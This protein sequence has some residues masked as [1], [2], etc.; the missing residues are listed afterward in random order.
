[1]SLKWKNGKS[2]DVNTEHSTV[3]VVALKPRPNNQR[4]FS[5]HSKFC[6]SSRMFVSLATIKAYFLPN[7]FA[8]DEQEMFLK[9]FE[10]IGKQI[11]FFEQ[12]LVMF[13]CCWKY[14]H[15]MD[16]KSKTKCTSSI[17]CSFCRSF[18][19]GYSLLEL[20]VKRNETF[21]FRVLHF[22]NI[23]TS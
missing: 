2:I 1:M 17:F 3:V 21:K 9:S 8:C 22:R 13:W 10:N 12:C 6:L 20:V 5:G 7:F 14:D 15:T 11:L 23:C 18:R 19:V 4:M 16:R